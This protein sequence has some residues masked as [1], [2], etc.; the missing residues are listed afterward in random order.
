MPWS[1]KY[2]MSTRPLKPK[3][4]FQRLLDVREDQID[5]TDSPPTTAAD[6][7][8]AEVLFP[9]TPE[10]FRAIKKFILTRREQNSRAS[11]HAV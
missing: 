8:D 4:Y 3:E 2:I 6:W 1:G 7:E 11:H 5:Y 9:V 10:E